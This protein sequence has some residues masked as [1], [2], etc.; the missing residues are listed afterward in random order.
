MVATDVV[1]LG[2]LDER[3]DVGLLQVLKLVLVGSSKVG[4]HAAVVAGDH[5]TTLASRL[6][7]I[8]TVLGV[9]TGLLTGLLEDVGVLVLTN[10]ANV[11]D[12]V[13]GQHVL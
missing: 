13:G 7:V 2:L 8:D 6:L 11:G 5:N 4:T 3:P 12:R 10:T 1:H 9:D